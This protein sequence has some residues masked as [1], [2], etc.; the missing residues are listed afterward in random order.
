M[1]RLV[2]PI[3]LIMYFALP[4][5]F[6][7]FGPDV[8]SMAQQ[9][10]QWMLWVGAADH[11]RHVLVALWLA[12]RGAKSSAKSAALHQTGVLAMAQIKG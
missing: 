9:S 12:N 10:T 1:R 3:F 5:M 8:D 6:G 7:S 2:G 4:S 11:R